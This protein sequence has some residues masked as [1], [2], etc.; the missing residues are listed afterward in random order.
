MLEARR[1]C[2]ASNRGVG[3]ITSMPVTRVA[4]ASSARKAIPP[5]TFHMQPTSRKLRPGA[6]RRTSSSRAGSTPRRSLRRRSRAAVIS[7]RASRGIGARGTIVVVPAR[8][9]SPDDAQAALRELPSVEELAGRLAAPH[10]L[11]VAAARE[12]I[13]ARRAELLAGEAGEADLVA[14]ASAA[15]ERGERPSLRRVLNATGVIVHT[16]LGRAPLAA[17]ARAA[18]ARAAEGYANLELELEAG[19]R[20]S[21]QAHVGGLLCELTGAEAALAVNNGAAA[22]LLA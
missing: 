14:R 19:R 11:A 21:R 17:A 1:A 2:S 5:S 13:A 6:Y 12:A 18:A 15:L 22:V 8:R 7:A 9:A 20:G 3:A 4:P 10:A 16:N